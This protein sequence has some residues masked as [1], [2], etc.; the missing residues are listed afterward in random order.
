METYVW[1]TGIVLIAAGFLVKTFPM[2]IAGYNTMSKEEQGNID[3]KKVSSVMR[4]GLVVSGITVIGGTY[5][6]TWLGISMVANAIMPIAI[7]AGVIIILVLVQKH[8]HNQPTPTG[9]KGRWVVSAVLTLSVL[10]ILRIVMWGLNP[11]K[12][13]VN[14]SHLKINGMYGVS[15]YFEG[16]KSV[17][18]TDTMPHIALRV[19]GF[20]LGTINKGIFNI[21]SFGRSRLYLTSLNPPLMV[22]T[23]HKDEKI[24][25]NLSDPELTQEKYL[26]LKGAIAKNRP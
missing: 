11:I 15:L 13:D 26:E 19:N 18:L 24:F 17:E 23:N 22:I 25:I 5:L 12:V 10:V 1:V 7:I 16:M 8:N 4:N 2:L 9:K 20:S 6:F 14:K 21:E 3:I